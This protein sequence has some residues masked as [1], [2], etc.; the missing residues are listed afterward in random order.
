[1][2]HGRKATL[3]FAVNI[4]HINALVKNFLANGVEAKGI[5]SSTTNYERE[6]I[7][8]DFADQKFPVLIN[9][10]ILTEGVDMPIIDFLMLARP[11]KSSVLLQQ[12][13]G[14]GM[15]LYPGKEFCLVLDFVDMVSERMMIATVPTLL[16]IDVDSAAPKNTMIANST[17][18]TIPEKLHFIFDNKYLKL[19]LSPFFNPFGGGFFKYYA[20][21][22]KW[23]FITSNK[24]H[25]ILSTM[26]RWFQ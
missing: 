5:S 16:G 19:I 9:C 6:Q 17:L 1:M 13:L 7:L 22:L 8:K 2:L 26:P 21:E 18:L 3:V 25:R 10:G 15:R 12:M 23:K 11:T 24:I 20:S 4:A 14:R